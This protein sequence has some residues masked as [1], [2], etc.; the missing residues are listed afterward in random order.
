MTKR[1]LEALYLDTQ[2][3]VAAL[4]ADAGPEAATAPVPACPSWRVKDVVAHLT[5]LCADVLSGNIAGAATDEWTAAQVDARRQIPLA[6]VLAEWEDLAPKFAVMIDDFPGRY[7]NQVAADLAVH[8]QDLRGALGRPGAR[9]SEALTKGID[10]LL[11]TVGDPGATA[12]GLGPLEISADGHSWIIGTG[13]A[14]AGDPAAAIE[15]ALMTKEMPSPQR[16]DAKAS[17]KGDRFELFRAMTGRRSAEQI[18]GFQWSTDPEPYLPLFAQGP[19]TL[20]TADLV[21]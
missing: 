19:F 6:E 13:E 3:R 12:L 7:G 14:A 15:T 5:G 11:S 20:R 2:D 9:D 1:A 8:E 18:R 4:V 21:E 10:F 17:L 16:S